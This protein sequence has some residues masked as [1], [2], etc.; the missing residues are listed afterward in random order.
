AIQ[1]MSLN[2]RDGDSEPSPDIFATYAQFIHHQPRPK[3]AFGAHDEVLFS[4]VS[5]VDDFP[6]GGCVAVMI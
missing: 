3:D 4:A 1:P 6:T 2:L 5:R